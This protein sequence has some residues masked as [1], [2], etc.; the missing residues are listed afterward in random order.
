MTFWTGVIAALEALVPGCGHRALAMFRRARP[1]TPPSSSCSPTSREPFPSAVLVIDDFHHVDRN[2]AVASSV[3]RFVRQPPPWLH[4]VL[5]SRRDPDVPI[6]RMRS[7]GQLGEV[8]FAE[9]R[10]STAEAVEL[11]RLLAP[12]LPGP[13]VDATVEQAD[14]SVT[15]LRLAALAARSARAGG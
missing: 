13:A 12:S 9:L 1:G 14:G 7:R 4:V 5:I 10:F 2:E 11:L 6:D 3:A 15:S 8:R